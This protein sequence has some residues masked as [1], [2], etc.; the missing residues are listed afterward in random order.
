MAADM[1]PR[2]TRNQ[3]SPVLGKYTRMGTSEAQVQESLLQMGPYFITCQRQ[4]AAQCA[5]GAVKRKR[6]EPFFTWRWATN[7]DKTA[8]ERVHVRRVEGVCTGLAPVGAAHMSDALR[9]PKKGCV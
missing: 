9:L 3:P 8:Q 4:A 2:C 1:L 7:K 5:G 6:A